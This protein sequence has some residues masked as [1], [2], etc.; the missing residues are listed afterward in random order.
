[1]MVFDRNPNAY[2]FDDYE[3]KPA[4]LPDEDYFDD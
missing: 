1:M 3:T 2:W 4:V